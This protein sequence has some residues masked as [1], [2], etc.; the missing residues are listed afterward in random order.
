MPGQLPHHSGEITEHA[1]EL[2]GHFRK[3]SE[4]A[5][6]LAEM[7]GELSRQ[8]VERV[9]WIAELARELHLCYQK[10]EKHPVKLHGFAGVLPVFTRTIYL[11]LHH[12]L[13][14]SD[15]FA[16]LSRCL[17]DNTA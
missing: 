14:L 1:G 10:L 12:W 8:I 16:L 2:S 3:F 13:Q 5:S 9:L 17:P 11:L 15:G 4:M 7:S 6:M